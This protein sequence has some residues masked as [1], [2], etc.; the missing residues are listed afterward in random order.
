MTDTPTVEQ[1]A[2]ALAATDELIVAIDD[3]QWSNPTPQL[4]AFLGRAMPAT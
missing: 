4:A 1:L 3:D 2:R